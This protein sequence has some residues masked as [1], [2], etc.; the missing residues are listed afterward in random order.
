MVV[1]SRA[2]AVVAMLALA[3]M[4]WAQ[5]GGSELTI[6]GPGNREQRC[7][8]VRTWREPDGRIAYEVQAVPGGER[9]TLYEDAAQSAAANRGLRGPVG[10]DRLAPARNAA[11]EMVVE[12]TTVPVPAAVPAPQ[13]VTPIASTPGRGTQVVHAS[14]S[15]SSYNP[16]TPTSGR[17][18]AVPSDG[19]HA[20]QEPGQA[21]S[22]TADDGAPPAE[23][24][25]SWGTPSA[26]D[27][28]AGAR[29]RPVAGSESAETKEI[30]TGSPCE[31]G[32]PVE[33][34][35][36]CPPR[37]GASLLK[38]LRRSFQKETP[39][40]SEPPVADGNP[41]GPPQPPKLGGRSMEVARELSS[42]GLEM[43][44]DWDA[45]NA[46][47]EPAPKQRSWHAS[48]FEAAAEGQSSQRRLVNWPSWLHRQAPADASAPQMSRPQQL[49]APQGAN[50]P[51]AGYGPQAQAA[52]APQALSASPLANAGGRNAPQ[53][54]GMLQN[55]PYPSHREWAADTLAGMDGRPH[56]LVVA[57]LLR[58]ASS[59][60]APAVRASCV[61]GL[62][63]LRA[64]SPAV[65]ASLE[66]LRA[67]ADANVRQEAQGALT[68][69][70]AG[71]APRPMA[72]AMVRPV[73]GE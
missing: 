32:C 71:P 30:V 62:V 3:G 41:D 14:S 2:G 44:A 48:A 63:S 61:R 26:S 49:P 73:G 47:T 10:A 34:T 68:A 54:L 12:S 23:W 9:M 70:T 43:P 31:G 21:G 17:A 38:K 22:T 65:L 1:G 28:P 66:A 25:K 51:Q 35:G 5:A 16:V 27:Q 72:D 69:L 18:D 13:R 36:D 57:A 33:C 56:P 52:P 8:L 59:D 20:H 60:P 19:W 45:N 7:K 4:A 40:A 24:R 29:L 50:V 42:G 6:R 37:E 64:N 15:A 58:S 46:F 55:S 53:L 39:G 67:D 11:P